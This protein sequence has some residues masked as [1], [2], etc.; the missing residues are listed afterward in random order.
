MARSLG[1][2]A[3]PAFVDAD[4][5]LTSLAAAVPSF[6]EPVRAMRENRPAF[7]AA[8]ESS[9]KGF[10]EIPDAAVIFDPA[11]QLALRDPDDYL[12]L[13]TALEIKSLRT[14]RRR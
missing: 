9:K 12:G 10:V 5:A 13:A 7:L 11:D 3:F 14:A 2:A 1:A 4:D 8:A 6:A